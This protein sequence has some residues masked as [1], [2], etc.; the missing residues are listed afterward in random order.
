VS[1]STRVSYARVP[2]RRVV[3]LEPNPPLCTTLTYVCVLRPAGRAAKLS[4]S[5][6]LQAL[7]LQERQRKPRSSWLHDWFV[8]YKY[9]RKR[10]PLVYFSNW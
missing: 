8:E 2:I 3:A 7:L 10:E 5:Y 9:L 6:V 1:Q 4:E